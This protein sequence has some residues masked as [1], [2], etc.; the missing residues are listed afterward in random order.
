MHPTSSGYKT[1]IIDSLKNNNTLKIIIFS[2]IFIK[3]NFKINKV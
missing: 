2:N 3:M 1:R